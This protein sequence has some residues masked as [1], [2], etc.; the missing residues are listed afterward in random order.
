VSAGCAV[1]VITSASVDAVDADVLS[2]ISIWQGEEQEIILS[3]EIIDHM[4]IT[5]FTDGVIK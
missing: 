2:L 1:Q 5:F 3:K 4:N